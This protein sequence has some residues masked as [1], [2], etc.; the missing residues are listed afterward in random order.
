MKCWFGVA[1][2]V[3]AA[4]VAGVPSARADG[5]DEM[6]KLVKLTEESICEPGA[7]ELYAGA[8]LDLSSPCAGRPFADLP[9]PPVKTLG[10]P[11][12]PEP[13]G[14]ALTGLGLLALRRRRR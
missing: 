11:T 10:Q 12:T 13:A 3:A 2:A 5:L 8:V 6:S 14:L 1:V 9:N 4:I 7:D